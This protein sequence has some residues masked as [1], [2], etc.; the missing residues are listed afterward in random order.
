MCKQRGDEGENR[1][2][3]SAHSAALV[4][5]HLR[6]S[7]ACRSDVRLGVVSVGGRDLR[8]LSIYCSDSRLFT[9]SAGGRQRYK[10]DSRIFLRLSDGNR[11]AENESPYAGV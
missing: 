7:H 1:G 8:S 6:F 10:R 3:K 5:I 2:R 11:Q 9:A 4:R